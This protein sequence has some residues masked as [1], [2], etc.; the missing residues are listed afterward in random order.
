VYNNS[1]K[2]Q[3]LAAQAKD[4]GKLFVETARSGGGV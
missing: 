4:E 2:A 3:R 1:V